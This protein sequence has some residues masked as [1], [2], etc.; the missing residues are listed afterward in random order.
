M[1]SD[2]CVVTR[3]FVAKFSTAITR[4]TADSRADSMV[5]HVTAAAEYHGSNATASR[6]GRLI[7][8][9]ETLRV[10]RALLINLVNTTHA[11]SAA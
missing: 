9:R 11:S 1:H 5:F 7:T 2:P 8:T 3:P 10:V 6:F 4:T